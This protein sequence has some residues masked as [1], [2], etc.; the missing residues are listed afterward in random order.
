MTDSSDKPRR[1]VFVPPGGPGQLPSLSAEIY[2]SMGTEGVF[3]MLEAFYAELGRS[4]IRHIF[5][6]DLVAASQRSAAFY[7]QLFGGPPLYNQKYGNPMMR[8]RHLPFEINES[9][10]K[11]WRDC[12]YR[13][14]E[15]ADEF[16]F[17]D[18]HLED[19]RN[20]LDGFSR[21]MVNTLD[22]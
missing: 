13:I 17:P 15:R 2:A 7:V 12:F 20:W 1:D 11:V 8:A 5:S 21:W 22:T 18:G 6:E 10:R 4:E 9:A 16:G 3:G 14:L 19:F